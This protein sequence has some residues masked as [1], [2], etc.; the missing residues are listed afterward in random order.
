MVTLVV[1]N[2]PDDL[3]KRLKDVATANQCSL[4]VQLIRCLETALKPKL[5]DTEERL[6]RMRVLRPNVEEEVAMVE[7]INNLIF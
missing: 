1:K 4:N 2:L 5:I 7:D 6:S 3:Y